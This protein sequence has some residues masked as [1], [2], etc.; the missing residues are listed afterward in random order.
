M[1]TGLHPSLPVE[2]HAFT[3]MRECEG[4]YVSANVSECL[5]VLY[6]RSPTGM[7]RSMIPIMVDA[8]VV[9]VSVG[10]NNGSPAP[11]MPNPG[12]WRDEATNTS[13]LFMQTG[14]TH[15]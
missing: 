3:C 14:T 5:C 13:V 2:L 15:R 11:D 6:G 8:G 10:V 9:A 1:L 7:T 4:I 12:V